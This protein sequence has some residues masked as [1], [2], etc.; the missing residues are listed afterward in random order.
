MKSFLLTEARGLKVRTFWSEEGGFYISRLVGSWPFA[1]DGATEAESLAQMAE[2]LSDVPDELI[3]RMKAQEAGHLDES[4]D[5]E[6][7]PVESRA[8][9]LLSRLHE[10]GEED[11]G[12]K[13]IDWVAPDEDGFDNP[14]TM[15]AL[16]KFLKVGSLADVRQASG[17]E[18]DGPEEI[19]NL[20]YRGSEP[21]AQDLGELGDG[22]V[23][24]LTLDGVRL[25]HM[26]EPGYRGIYVA[27]DD[28][29]KVDMALLRK[30]QD[31]SH[32]E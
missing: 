5:D 25:A 3:A 2:A 30:H 15:M 16:L 21:G 23:T 24:G 26:S 27:S 19:D 17:V 13:P 6:G 11:A 31:P 9:D 8:A 12:E 14:G 10:A 28:T 22:Q 18:G 1:T 32:K 4:V 20:D 7:R 29:G